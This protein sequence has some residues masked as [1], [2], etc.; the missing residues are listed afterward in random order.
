MDIKYSLKRVVPAIVAGFFLSVP[1][2]AQNDSVPASQSMHQAGEK[3]EQAGSDTAAA[4]KDTYYGTERAAKDTT[5]TAKVKTALERDRS[6]G[7]SGIHVDTVAGIVTLKGSVPSPE[8]AQHAAKLAEQTEGVKSV[9][10][11]LMVITSAATD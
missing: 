4:A 1:A 8:M 3:I 2:F 7:G 9:N 11:Q 5:I 6:V 10:N